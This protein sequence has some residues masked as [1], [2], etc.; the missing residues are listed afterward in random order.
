M[1]GAVRRWL[2]ASGLMLASGVVVGLGDAG[3]PVVFEPGQAVLSKEADARLRTHLGRLQE[4]GKTQIEIVV[5]KENAD[6]PWGW[7]LQA[8]RAR[9][10]REIATAA[11]F[12]ADA[13]KVRYQPG[14]DER[15]LRVI[16][17]S[18]G[19]KMLYDVRA[20]HLKENV[21]RLL[22]SHGYGDPV[23]VGQAACV[24]WRIQKDHQIV[25]WRSAELLSQLLAGFPVR[26]SLH[27][28]DMTA[29]LAPTM[30]LNTRCSK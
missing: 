22:E 18:H 4:K 28:A 21:A 29:V 23:W 16:G 14:T 13:A 24:D 30:D 9:H 2:F 20:G 1:I 25:G 17:R 19:E 26:A 12:D 7:D 3:S 8:K 6:I 27:E 5:E 15:V 10:V 11:G